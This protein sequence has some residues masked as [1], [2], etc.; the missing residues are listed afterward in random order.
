[1]ANLI[2]IG[3]R[4]INLDLVKCFER[5]V[6]RNKLHVH[7]FTQKGGIV[8]NEELNNRPLNFRFVGEDAKILWEKLCDMADPIGLPSEMPSDPKE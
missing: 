4:I 5:V 7:L 2:R 8:G 3:D 6:K 1:M